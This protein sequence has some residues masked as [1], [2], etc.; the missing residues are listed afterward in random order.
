MGEIIE[1]IV[2]KKIRENYEIIWGKLDDLGYLEQYKRVPSNFSEFWYSDD[3]NFPSVYDKDFTLFGYRKN[4]K[5][6]YGNKNEIL[7]PEVKLL[8][9]KETKNITVKDCVN[10]LELLYTKPTGRIFENLIKKSVEKLKEF[11]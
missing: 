8:L 3:N 9:E 10:A 4:G 5:W 11:V 7:Y 2:S 1:I 6:C